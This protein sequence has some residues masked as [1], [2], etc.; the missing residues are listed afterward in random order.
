MEPEE[1]E[2][3]RR[4]LELSQKNNK[5]LHAIQRS[6]FWGKVFRYLYWAIIIGAAIGAYYFLDPYVNGVLDA[7]NSV[8]NNITHIIQK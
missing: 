5:M 1:R 6:M 8:K 2:M 3:L 4:V 7:Y